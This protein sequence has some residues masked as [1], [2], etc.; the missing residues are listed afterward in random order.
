MIEGIELINIII[1]SLIIFSIGL[2]GIFINRGNIIS[3]LMSIE[4]MMLS[5]NI[6][7]VAFSSYYGDLIGQIFV[8]FSLTI[9][10]AEAAIGLAILVLYNK[11]KGDIEVVNVN[12][13]SG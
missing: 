1:L 8:I 7:F 5:V 9:A 13:M 12:K 4:I 10:G 3:L 11:N 2:T 6:N